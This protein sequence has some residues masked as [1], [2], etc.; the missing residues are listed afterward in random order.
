MYCRCLLGLLKKIAAEITSSQRV[1]YLLYLYIL[2][3]VYMNGCIQFHLF[4]FYLHWQALLTALCLNLKLDNV[5]SFSIY[6]MKI[7]RA[8]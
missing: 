4:L 1:R 5:Y 2:T 8:S 7:K 3:S 6:E